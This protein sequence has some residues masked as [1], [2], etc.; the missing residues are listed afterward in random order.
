MTLHQLKAFS[1]V[2]KFGSFTEAAGALDLCQPSITILIKILEKELK[3]KLFDRLGNGIRITP[4]G[5]MVLQYSEN[6]LENSNRIELEAKKYNGLEKGRIIVGTSFTSGVSFVPK[7]IQEY[8][9]KY[10]GIVLSLNVDRSRALEKDLLEGKIDI[11]ILSHEVNSLQLHCIP[12]R[13]EKIVVIAPPNHPLASR[14]GISLELL[15]EESFCLSKYL[16]RTRK[17]IE[18]LFSEKGLPLNIT[19]ELNDNYGT[20]EA[21]KTAVACGMGLGFNFMCHVM[22]DV[23]AGRLTILDVPEIQLTQ[24][25]HV[26]FHKNRMNSSI[27]QS[28][29]K[30]LQEYN[31]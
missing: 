7:A 19:L 13:T 18:E 1:T 30:F 27:I 6:M 28:F 24:K 9:E 17:K 14:R 11:A 31:K 23:N 2:A 16:G 15:A 8:K 20:R 4:A 3:I 12:H 21:T 22:S 5:E 10:S 29:S 25:L 26:V